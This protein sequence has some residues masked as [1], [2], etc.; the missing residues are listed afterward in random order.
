M[1]HVEGLAVYLGRNFNPDDHQ[2]TNYLSSAENNQ[3]F[4]MRCNGFYMTR[5]GEW[6]HIPNVIGPFS[7]EFNGQRISFFG[8]HAADAFYSGENYGSEK[9]ST[10]L[11]QEVVTELVRKLRQTNEDQA[12][13]VSFILGGLVRHS[14]LKPVE[15]LIAQVG[16]VAR[17]TRVADER[18][19]DATASAMAKYVVSEGPIND[20]PRFTRQVSLM[21]DAVSR[22]PIIP[23]KTV[24]LGLSQVAR[25]RD[26][27]G[28]IYDEPASPL[29]DISDDLKVY[30][31]FPTIGAEFHFPV[32]TSKKRPNFWQRLALL[33]MSQYQ[34]GSYIQL[35]RNDKDVIEVRMNP[36]VYPVTVANWSR[37]MSI[38]PELQS[39]FF[40]LTLNRTTKAGDFNWN[41]DQDTSMLR[42]LKGIGLLCYAGLCQSIP[43]IGERAEIDFGTLYLGQTVRKSDQQYEFSGHWGGRTLFGARGDHGQIG[44][45]TG[46]GDMFPDLAHYTGMVLAA[47]QLLKYI[48]KKELAQIDTLA[49]AMEVP[50]RDKTYIFERIQANIQEDPDL[51]EVSKTSVKIIEKLETV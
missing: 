10:V 43:K 20:D 45:Y 34:R 49:K 35:S 25:L 6:Q 32:D 26:F 16:F 17:M 21:A 48:N 19:T 28:S 1:T 31:H 41:A 8:P 15:D 18:S 24:D 9:L 11:G 37:M 23:T 7:E 13:R 22:D 27:N 4:A 50:D 46:F 14:R 44:L 30:E 51:S 47:P 39:A 33:N 38:L 36:S 29:P 5:G 2:D 42:K 40:T 12:A 3:H